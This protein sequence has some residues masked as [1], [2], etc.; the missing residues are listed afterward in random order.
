MSAVSAYDRYF[1]M[2][3]GHIALKPEIAVSDDSRARINRIMNDQG[4]DSVKDDHFKAICFDAKWLKEN[5]LEDPAAKCACALVA[6][7][8]HSP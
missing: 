2:D 5:K 4:P 3:K 6:L 8:P 7:L 1:V